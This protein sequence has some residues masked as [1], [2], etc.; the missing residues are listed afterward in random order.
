VSRPYGDPL[1]VRLTNTLETIGADIFTAAEAVDQGATLGLT[2]THVRKLLHQLADSGLL[3]RVKRGT[4]AV[5]DPVTRAPKVHPF[6][7]GAALVTP[8]AISHWSAL[9]HWGLTQQIPSTVTLSSPSRTSPDARSDDKLANQSTRV[10]NGITYRLIVI[11]APRFFGITHV[12]LDERSR[13]PIFDRERAL[14]DTFHH[15]RIFGSLSV[16]LGILDA[17]LD[18]IDVE[19]LVAYSTRID[20]GAVAKRVGWALE[21]FGVPADQLEPLHSRLSRG[22]APLDPGRPAR[23]RHNRTWHVIENLAARHAQ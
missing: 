20:I 9:Q 12:W 7:I 8:S 10:V 5:N 6:A 11:K 15:F 1:G 17:H 18:D 2:A 21:M 22:D 3:M 4:Y 13:V 19:R 14:L 16:A 23:G